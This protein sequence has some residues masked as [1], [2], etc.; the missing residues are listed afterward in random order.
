MGLVLL[1]QT[2]Q[3]ENSGEVRDHGEIRLKSPF[4]DSQWEHVETLD[5]SSTPEEIYAK[6]AEMFSELE[7]HMLSVTGEEKLTKCPYCQIDLSSLPHLYWVHLEEHMNM[8]NSSPSTPAKTPTKTTPAPADMPS[9]SSTQKEA[10]QS[11]GQEA[12]SSPQKAQDEANKSHPDPEPNKEPEVA[13]IEP[14]SKGRVTRSK[15]KSQD[16]IRKELLEIEKKI[17]Q[18]KK[19]E[20]EKKRIEEEEKRKR[21]EQEEKEKKEEEERQK[22]VE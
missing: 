18:K 15:Q 9:P 21:A 16:Q 2:T 19:D 11:E 17:A 14:I 8:N 7:D 1:N 20:D 10:P 3:Q 13:G 12:T 5:V 6:A 22:K 4:P